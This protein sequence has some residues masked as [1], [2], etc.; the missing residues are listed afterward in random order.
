MGHVRQSSTVFHGGTATPPTTSWVRYFPGAHCWH[1]FVLSTRYSP[2]AHATVGMG[3]GAQVC[4]SLQRPSTM[5][6]QHNWPRLSLA[7]VTSNEV[8]PAES[9]ET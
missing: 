4:L 6:S 8:T 3:V 1:M 7:R 5:V 9:A 2:S